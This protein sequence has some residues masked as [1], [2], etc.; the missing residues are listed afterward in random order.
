MTR[1]LSNHPALTTILIIAVATVVT[2]MAIWWV[3]PQGEKALSAQQMVENVCAKVTYPDSFDISAIA[4]SKT[5][6]GSDWAST[7]YRRSPSGEHYIS[8]G[9]DGNLLVE[10]VLITAPD[11]GSSAGGEGN[12]ITGTESS[13]SSRSQNIY[14]RQADESGRLGE[15]VTATRELPATGSGQAIAGT[16]GA[17]QANPED[18]LLEFCGLPLE[19]EGRDVE[20]RYVGEEVINGVSTSHYYHSFSFIGSDEYYSTEYWIDSEGLFRQ[21]REKA[22]YTPPDEK[23]GTGQ[24]AEVLKIYSGWGEENVITAPPLTPTPTPQPTATPAPPAAPGRPTGSWSGGVASLDWNDVPGASSYEIRI[25]VAQGDDFIPFSGSGVSFAFDGSSA[26]VSGLP[27]T[28]HPYY[29]FGVRAVNARG[30]SELSPSKRVPVPQPIE[31]P[32]QPS[33]RLTGTGQVALDWNDVAGATSYI[34][35]LWMV[36]RYVTLSPAGPV[37]GISI[38]LDGSSAAVSGLPTGY[39]NY[40]F[41]VGA[42]GG[43]HRSLWSPNNQVPVP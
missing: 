40:F 28:G 25:W 23:G 37:N 6:A 27:G 39:D 36:D 22:V 3:L 32:E 26:T 19:I 17:A 4:T 18:D 5:S 38:A 29:Y 34:V 30:A 12:G 21:I 33:G 35:R 20:F 10:L 24:W 31:A 9:A 41:V 13:Q 2:A 8:Q 15:W 16:G 7:E 43:G 42:V 11:T 1:I 14:V